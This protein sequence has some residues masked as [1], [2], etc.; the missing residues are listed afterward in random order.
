MAI[1]AHQLKPLQCGLYILA[2]IAEIVKEYFKLFLVF[3][4]EFCYTVSSKFPKARFLMKTR[5]WIAVFAVILIIC[6]GAS[7]L[8]LSPGE[9]ASHAEISSNGS[10]IRTVDL[11]IDQEFTVTLDDGSYNTVTVRD[12]KIAVTEAS[13]PDQY[14][15]RRGWCDSGAQIVCLPNKL[16]ITFTDGQDVDFAVG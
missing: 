11:R 14:C 12:G 16:V 1:F 9:A 10:V 13:C 6:A 2:S 4:S 15:A 5:S 3:L 7:L 8:L